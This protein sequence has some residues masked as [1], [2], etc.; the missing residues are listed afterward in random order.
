MRG[1]FTLPCKKFVA[2]MLFPFHKLSD[3]LTN[4]GRESVKDSEGRDRKSSAGEAYF[5]EKKLENF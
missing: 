1:K 2:I 4:S 5:V 3:G